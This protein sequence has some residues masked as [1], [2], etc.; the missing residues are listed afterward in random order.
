MASWGAAASSGLSEMLQ[1]HWLAE[2]PVTSIHIAWRSGSA[3]WS[4]KPVT[5]S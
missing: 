1:V 2:V 3:T 4:R 5:L